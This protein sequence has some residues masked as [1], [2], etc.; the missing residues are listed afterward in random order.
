MSNTLI[1]PLEAEV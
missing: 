1:P